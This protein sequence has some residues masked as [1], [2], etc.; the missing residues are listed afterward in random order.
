MTPAGDRQALA[1]FCEVDDDAEWDEEL[2]V[3]T[4]EEAER[5]AE[6]ARQRAECLR[7]VA[8]P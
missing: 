4:E 7:E 2:D 5:R 8:A 6:R 1:P 3:E